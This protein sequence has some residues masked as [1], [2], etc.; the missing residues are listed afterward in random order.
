MS[1]DLMFLRKDDDQ[2]WDEV[3]EEAEEWEAEDGTGG[4]PDAAAWALIVTDARRILGAEVEEF[5][6]A[7][8]FELSHGPTGIQVSLYNAE[9]GITVPYWYKGADAMVII[10]LV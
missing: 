5:R 9:A 10:E 3:L 4:P 7:E 8:A 2:S 1:Y 6:S